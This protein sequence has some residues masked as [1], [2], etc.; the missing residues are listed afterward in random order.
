[1]VQ[2]WHGIVW[3]IVVRYDTVRYGGVW[4]TNDNAI[5]KLIRYFEFDRN[6]CKVKVLSLM[7]RTDELGNIG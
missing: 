4:I 3:Y 7:T 2:Y 6:C 5:A 1:M